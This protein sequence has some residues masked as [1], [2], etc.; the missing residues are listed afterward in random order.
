MGR[1]PKIIP[2]R[3]N[4][5]KLFEDEETEPIQSPEEIT[6]KMRFLMINEKK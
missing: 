3:N 6:K 2:I 5:K 1:N 4:Y